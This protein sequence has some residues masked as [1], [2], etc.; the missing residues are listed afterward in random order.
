M[1]RRSKLKG[2][3]KKLA[4]VFSVLT[5]E[6]DG[7]IRIMKDFED[8]RRLSFGVEDGMKVVKRDTV[9]RDN[10]RLHYFKNEEC[11]SGIQW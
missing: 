8:V 11:S 7:T 10:V 4:L 5:L 6:A 1:M 3:S 9:V 2:Q